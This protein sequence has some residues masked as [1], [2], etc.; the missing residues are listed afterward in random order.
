MGWATLAPIYFARMLVVMIPM[1]QGLGPMMEIIKAGLRLL[2][3]M[4]G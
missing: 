1:V 4:I 3:F 2:D